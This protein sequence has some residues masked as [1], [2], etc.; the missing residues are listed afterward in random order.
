MNFVIFAVE[1]ALAYFSQQIIIIRNRIEFDRSVRLNFCVILSAIN[2]L[3]QMHEK[4]QEA[5][6]EI[7]NIR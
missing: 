5:K 7:S 4:P 6:T 1:H 3:E 2:T